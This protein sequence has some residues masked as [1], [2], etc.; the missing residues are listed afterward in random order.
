MADEEEF[1]EVDLPPNQHQIYWNTP[2]SR[3]Y[4]TGTDRGVLYLD[5]QP[6]VPWNGLV[7]VEETTAGGEIKPFYLDGVRRRNDHF[8]EEFQATIKAFSC[9]V[10][11]AACEG[12][13]EL[14]P[15]LFLGQQMRDSFGFSYRTMIGDDVNGRDANYELHLVYQAMTEP[16]GRTH[17]TVSDDPEAQVREWEIHT[18]PLD[19]LDARP[20][21]HIRLDTRRV[22][23]D[24]LAEIEGILYGHELEPRL[25]LISEIFQILSREDPVVIEEEIPWEDYD[26]EYIP[27]EP[28][29]EDP[30]S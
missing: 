17:E 12:E 30:N 14:A 10:E 3:T 1:L 25:P 16:S 13:M 20:S 7:S 22:R 28:I 2:G 11:F 8:L 9:P 18:L 6:G 26:P 27:E 29:L 15:G 24:R 23:L 21:A 19:V 5:E 4:F